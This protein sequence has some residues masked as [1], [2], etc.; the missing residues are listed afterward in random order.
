MRAALRAVLAAAALFSLTGCGAAVVAALDTA[1]SDATKSDCSISRVL[2]SEP[3][4]KAD[5]LPPPEE[6]LYCYRTIGTIN[7]YRSED[8]NAGQLIQNPS[9]RAGG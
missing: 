3:L 5:A 9:T 4:C 7:C 1:M 6:K 8:P 2:R